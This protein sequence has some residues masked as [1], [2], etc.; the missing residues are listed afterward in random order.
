MERLFASDN[1]AG[2]HPKVMRALSDTNVG[3]VRGYG[4]DDYTRRATERIHEV[5]GDKCYPFY[6]FN[7]GGGNMVA[8]ASMLSQFESV[9]CEKGAHIN[10]DECGA[11]ERMV[12]CKLLPIEAG[13]YTGKIS[14]VSISKSG[15]L[16]QRDD[17]HRTQPKVLSISNATEIGAVYHPNELCPLTE[18]TEENDLLVH[19]DGARLA[20]AAAYLGVSLAQLTG[21]AGVTAVT[22]GGTKSG[23]MFGEVVL[24]FDEEIADRARFIQKQLCQL[25]S[26]QRFIAAQVEALLSDDL[27]L[28]NARHANNM[29]LML[30][31]RLLN[32][33]VDIAYTVRT[34]A[35]FIRLNRARASRLQEHTHFYPWDKQ[36]DIYRLMTSWDTTEE[37]V[38]EFGRLLDQTRR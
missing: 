10:T 34:N 7:G 28:E 36:R 33:G 38:A 24:I 14:P 19:V 6:V 32:A 12:G 17:V 4:D 3:H 26:K 20:N 18:Y 11:L 15:Y 8:L 23:L 35:V 5:F 29:A 22:F 16:S 37:D 1:C 25:A 27:W 13:N 21:I 9:I 2:V 31:A 30:E